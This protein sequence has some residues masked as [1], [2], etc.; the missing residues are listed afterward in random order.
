MKTR[1]D[2]PMVLKAG[3]VAEILSV[4]KRFAYEVMEYKDFP[5]IRL[6]S[7]KRV[8]KDAFFRWLDNYENKKDE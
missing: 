3:H 7:A 6:G 8:Q 2:Y 5:L 1:D 4:S